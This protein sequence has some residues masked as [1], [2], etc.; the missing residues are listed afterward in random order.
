MPAVPDGISTRPVHNMLADLL[1]G[2]ANNPDEFDLA[3]LVHDGIVALQH[4]APVYEEEAPAFL[5]QDQDA[6]PLT[7]HED[8]KAI[9][10][11]GL[12]L[13]SFTLL[14]LVVVSFHLFYEKA[15]L[16]GFIVIAP[17]PVSE[18]EYADNRDTMSVRKALT[19]MFTRDLRGVNVGGVNK[20]HEFAT[21]MNRNIDNQHNGSYD[22]TEDGNTVGS[23]PDNT[24]DRDRVHVHVNTRYNYG[25]G[26]DNDND[27]DEDESNNNIVVSPSERWAQQHNMMAVAGISGVEFMPMPMPVEG[28][29][30]PHSHSYSDTPHESNAP[31]NK[32]KSRL[33]NMLASASEVLHLNHKGDTQQDASAA[34]GPSTSVS[35]SS[36]RSIA[37]TRSSNIDE[38][39]ALAL[40][41]IPEGRRVSN[42][43][44]SG[45]S[46]L[47]QPSS[48]AAAH[49][50]DDA[51]YTRASSKEEE[52]LSTYIRQSMSLEEVELELGPS[53]RK[54][55][56]TSSSASSAAATWATVAKARAIVAKRKLL[57]TIGSTADIMQEA[58]HLRVSSSKAEVVG[59]EYGS[60]SFGNDNENNKPKPPTPSPS[61]T[62]TSPNPTTVSGKLIPPPPLTLPPLADNDNENEGVRPPKASLLLNSRE[63]T[64]HSTQAAL[65]RVLSEDD[66]D[67]YNYIDNHYDGD[68]Y[69]NENYDGNLDLLDDDG[70]PLVSSSAVE[71]SI[72]EDPARLRLGPTIHSKTRVPNQVTD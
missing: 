26:T 7:M 38:R 68:N 11:A 42:A 1:E 49:D 17:P 8:G 22:S 39:G 57:K 69:E 28:G 53:N 31:N 63:E 25:L 51:M 46:I 37:S 45:N 4:P 65:A 27:E 43:N 34:A 59:A 35:V 55:G 32:F 47:R 19:E 41:A 20:K 16:E 6:S 33:S 50:G 64:H 71:V 9:G 13:I 40:Q 58:N 14:A 56:G 24:P 18:E 30:S 61:P 10:A 52:D 36:Q 29:S 54:K 62:S 67:D 15:V 70:Y 48:S 2:M 3:R 12:L 44:A 66:L 5:R 21:S 60:G 72:W 23:S